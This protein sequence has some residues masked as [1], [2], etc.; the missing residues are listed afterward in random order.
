MAMM[1]TVERTR[2]M[3]KYVS[4]TSDGIVRGFG[5]TRAD[6]KADAATRPALRN[7]I[8]VIFYSI[9]TY[10]VS[11]RIGRKVPYDLWIKSRHVSGGIVQ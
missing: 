3:Y 9:P 6:A 4:V 8:C 1:P 5:N 7:W 11:M 2:A 10:G